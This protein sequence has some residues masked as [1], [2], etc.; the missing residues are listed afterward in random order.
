MLFQKCQDADVIL[1]ALPTYC[2]HL[3]STYFMFS[4]RSQAIF[5]DEEQY[6]HGFLRKLHFIIIG[7]VSSGGEM[8]AHEAL[9]T[10]AGKEFYPETLLLSARDY[11]QKAIAGTLIE[12]EQVRYRLDSFSQRI[13][14]RLT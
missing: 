11:D 5:Q 7:N 4:E 12:N 14:K 1:F 10:F 9:C 13:R 2:G 3:P 6:E 8:S